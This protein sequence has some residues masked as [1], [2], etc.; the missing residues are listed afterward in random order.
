[1]GGICRTT[2]SAQD[3][4]SGSTGSVSGGQALINTERD[5]AR[6]WSEEVIQ[7]D[8]PLSHGQ[9]TGRTRPRRASV[10][11]RRCLTHYVTVILC[12]GGGVLVLA[13]V[14]CTEWTIPP[15]EGTPFKTPCV[16]P[17][18]VAVEPVG[19][20]IPAQRCPSPSSFVIS[21]GRCTANR[22]SHDSR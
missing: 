20:P 11:Q 22:S 2:H 6:G 12:A 13:L 3:N 7:R 1:M 19:R 5:R 18:T 21:M 17:Y 15:C 10:S 8:R 14:G 4:L 9:A 16:G